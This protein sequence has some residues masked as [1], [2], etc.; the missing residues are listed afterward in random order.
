MPSLA[1]RLAEYILSTCLNPHTAP[2][3]LLRCSYY[4]D[5]NADAKALAEAAEALLLDKFDECIQPRLGNPLRV[6]ELSQLPMAM[7]GRILTSDKLGLGASSGDEELVLRTCTNVLRQRMDRRHI[8]VGMEMVKPLS[9]AV[10]V[11]LRVMEGIASGSECVRGDPVPRIVEGIV[12]LLDEAPLGEVWAEVEWKLSSGEVIVDELSKEVFQKPQQEEDEEEEDDGKE[13]SLPSGA[14][15]R[16]TLRS[17]EPVQ[18]PEKDSGE[19]GGD[20]DV[21]VEEEGE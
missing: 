1:H 19:S 12:P 13:V 14:V 2:A 21:A 6:Y 20:E 9:G 4:T 5:N 15:V 11:K 7:I 3:V 16:V 8:R 17:E 18:E 10:E